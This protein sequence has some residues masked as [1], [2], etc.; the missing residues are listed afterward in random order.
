MKKCF[1][2]NEFQNVKLWFECHKKWIVGNVP[3]STIKPLHKNDEEE[4]TIMLNWWYCANK[5]N[6]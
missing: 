1:D 4:E 2:A 6:A 3:S 5:E